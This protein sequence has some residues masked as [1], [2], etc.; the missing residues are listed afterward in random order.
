MQAKFI[1]TKPKHY[2]V[3]VSR[4][5]PLLLNTGRIRDQWHTMTRTGT[6]HKL[7]SHIESPYIEMHPD[8]LE[9]YDIKADSYASLNNEFGEYVGK[10]LEN[11]A[12]RIG[13]IFAPIHWTDEFAKLGVVSAV[14]SPEVDPFSGQPES[15]ATPVNIKPLIADRWASLVV[16]ARFVDAVD[17]SDLVYWYKTPCETGIRYFIAVDEEHNWQDYLNSFK[18]EGTHELQLGDQIN[19]DQRIVWL[20]GDDVILALY[21][22]SEPNKLPSGAWLTQLLD[23]PV[24]G[25]AHA[26]LLGEQDAPIKMICTCF[27]IAE[28]DIVDEIK[29]GCSTP[30]AL[31]EKLKCGTNCGSCI[32]ELKELIAANKPDIH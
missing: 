23:K 22:A 26:L 28:S 5:T 10:V 7:L 8:D 12:V 17:V 30:E 19:N 24:K 25:S 11:D 14:V 6:S 3:S 20:D 31:G 29:Q 16:D 32:P 21:S 27:Q 1:A 13:D 4:E 15:K 9:R 18:P 2:A